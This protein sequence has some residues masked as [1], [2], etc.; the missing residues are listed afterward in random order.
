MPLH[1]IG[2]FQT[3]VFWHAEN[4]L[5]E[6]WSRVAQIG[7]K[8]HVAKQFRPE[9]LKGK[10]IKRFIEYASLRVRQAVEFREAALDSSTLTS[11]LS[12]YYSFLNLIRGFYA[13]RV[14][15]LSVGHGLKL[16]VG[17]GLFGCRAKFEKG[18]FTDYLRANGISFKPKQT[19]TLREALRHV[20]EIRDEYRTTFA[21]DFVLVRAF[22]NG[23]VFFD[24]PDAL[25]IHIPTDWEE[26]YP[27]L[28]SV[29]SHVHSDTLRATSLYPEYNDVCS[30]VSS[31]FEPNLRETL[32]PSWFVIR[33]Y[34]G[35]MLLP[36]L[37]YYLI[38]IFILGSL[39]RYETELVVGIAN[40][41]TE[42][43]WFIDRFLKTAD[44]FVPQLA[45][46]WLGGKPVYF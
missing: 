23:E 20:I 46:S 44:R 25:G 14:E 31:L 30:L 29:C 7:V 38:A 15:Q 42:I 36:R 34:P 32:S 22:M 4:P 27:Q 28:R 5:A 12:L 39:V 41:N 13:L 35:D 17:D 19:V 33:R 18:T 24:L 11:P 3:G 6:V 1:Q 43:G 45:L 2:S 9:K 26:R 40:L 8:E 37:A 10:D 16:Q 21:A